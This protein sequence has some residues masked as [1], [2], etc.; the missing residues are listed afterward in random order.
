MPTRCSTKR[1]ATLRLRGVSPVSGQGVPRLVATRAVRLCIWVAARRWGCAGQTG[2]R[3][4]DLSLDA[5]RV[6]PVAGLEAT[7]V[8]AS[9][10]G[11]NAFHLQQNTWVDARVLTGAHARRRRAWVKITPRTQRAAT[12]SLAARLA[13]GLAWSSRDVRW[14]QPCVAH[15]RPRLARS[16]QP[17][18]NQ[19]RVTRR[20]GGARHP[21]HSA[22]GSKA[23]DHRWSSHG[24]GGPGG[25]DG[26][27]APHNR[28]AAVL[29]LE[30]RQPGMDMRRRTPTPP[31]PN[32]KEI[33]EGGKRKRAAVM[34]TSGRR[35]SR[36]MLEDGRWRGE[37]VRGDVGV[38]G[39][40]D[41]PAPVWL[42]LPTRTTSSPSLERRLK[43]SSLARR[44]RPDATA[45]SL[46]STRRRRI[47]SLSLTAWSPV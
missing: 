45:P 33:K 38:L 23:G 12:A 19:G 34:L 41:V 9:R 6:D 36:G 47:C 5:Q 29:R 16:A 22:L 27:R 40:V 13:G 30:G 46:G 43:S 35:C 10:H 39:G 21:L 7:A 1:R 26:P 2:A 24:D 20:S 31:V 4:R 15:A 44:R 18:G 25:M 8:S 42:P 3:A 14:P 17:P 37:C 28:G 11:V 32:R